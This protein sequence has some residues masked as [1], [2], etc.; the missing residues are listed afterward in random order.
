[1]KTLCKK[2]PVIYDGN[3]YYVKLFKRD[4][5]KYSNSCT[6]RIYKRILFF[7][8]K[9]H[10]EDCHYSKKIIDSDYQYFAKETI[11]RYLKLKEYENA[12]KKAFNMWNGK[13]N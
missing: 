4:F 9:L 13:C 5:E 11:N 12:N 10:E 2:F 6:T 1:M 7:D 8:I 3:K